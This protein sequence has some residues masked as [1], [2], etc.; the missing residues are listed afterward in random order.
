MSEPE[1]VVWM[2][3]RW[4]KRGAV[5]TRTY[6]EKGVKVGADWCYQVILI[7]SCGHLGGH[8]VTSLVAS[9]VAILW[10]SCGHLNSHLG[11]HLGGH[12]VIIIFVITIII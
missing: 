11:G 10:S 4:G 8:L 12:L 9:L 6:G 3:V 2:E 1:Y 5:V 7:L